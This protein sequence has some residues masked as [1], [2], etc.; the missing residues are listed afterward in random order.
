MNKQLEKKVSSEPQMSEDA[1]N[2]ELEAWFEFRRLRQDL[3]DKPNS[4]TGV[5]TSKEAL[6]NSFMYGLLSFNS[7]NGE[8]TQKISFPLTAKDSGNVILDKLVYKPRLTR[9]DVIEAGKGLKLNDMEGKQAS[10]LAAI[11]GK[12]IGT[13]NKLDES[14]RGLGDIIAG[15]FLQ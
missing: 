15:Y 13:L 8:L 9:L 7:E 12:G 6:V 2:A 11:T 3:R 4:I 10:Y 5:D 14:D 1:A